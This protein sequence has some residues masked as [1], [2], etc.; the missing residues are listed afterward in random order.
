MI[1]LLEFITV[2]CNK[3]KGNKKLSRRR[4]K[5]KKK[6]DKDRRKDD[7]NDVNGVSAEHK[8]NLLKNPD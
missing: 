6:C 1:F 4:H 8:G 5:S 2:L 7:K 3:S